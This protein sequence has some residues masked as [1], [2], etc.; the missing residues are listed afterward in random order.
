[1]GRA[2]LASAP[3]HFS[4]IRSPMAARPHAATAITGIIMYMY[5]QNVT[6]SAP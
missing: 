3:F 2:P 5:A 6:I 1:M 4:A